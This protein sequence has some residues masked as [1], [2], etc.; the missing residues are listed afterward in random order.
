MDT[1]TPP[2]LRTE[3]PGNSLTNSVHPVQRKA[4]AQRHMSQ[5]QRTSLHRARRAHRKYNR[6]QGV[7]HP[8]THKA[9][10]PPNE[11]TAVATIPPVQTSHENVPS[12]TPSRVCSTR[13]SPGLHVRCELCG[14]TYTRPAQAVRTTCRGS[15]FSKTEGNLQYGSPERTL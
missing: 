5:R 15:S 12:P 6:E 1:V 7:E 3:H 9:C 14:V 4:C 8:P 11:F 2:R 13:V 10:R